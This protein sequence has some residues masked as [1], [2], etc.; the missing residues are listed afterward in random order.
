MTAIEFL[1]RQTGRIRISIEMGNI[2]SIDKKDIIPIIHVR[3]ETVGCYTTYTL[4]EGF[5]I[6]SAYKMM[7]EDLNN[8]YI[9]CEVCGHAMR[10]DSKCYYNHNRPDLFIK[11]ENIIGV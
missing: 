10:K 8:K 6:E 11:D 4:G 3:V 1:Q 9:V 5:T 7:E 2:L